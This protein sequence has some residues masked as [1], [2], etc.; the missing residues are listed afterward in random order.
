MNNK[1]RVKRSDI[2][3]RKRQFSPIQRWFHT[4][5]MLIF[6]LASIEGGTRFLLKITK[7]KTIAILPVKTV[8]E[9][10]WFKPHPH[11]LYIF[12]PNGSFTMDAFGKATI[13]SNQF[14][15]RSTREFDVKTRKKPKNSLRIATLGGS[16][17]MGVN[18]DNEI[19]PYL[20][21]KNLKEQYPEKQ[22]EIL[23]E[24]IMGYTSLDNLL[25]LSTRIIDFDPDIYV[26]YLGVN[27]ILA[28]AP[29]E[30][31]Q[32]D[33]SH[34][35][36][37]LYEQLSLSYIEFLPSWLYRLKSVRLLLEMSGVTDRRD[38][39]KNTSTV[40][41]RKHFELNAKEKNLIERKI[42]KNLRRNLKSMIAVIRAH[43]SKAQIVLGSFFDLEKRKIIEKMNK[44]FA[45]LAEK[46]KLIF[47]DIAR[48]I[49][50]DQKMT[51][52][53]GHFTK[54][55]DQYIAKLLSK[56][57]IESLSTNKQN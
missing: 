51:Y 14:S 1:N 54:E 33:H 3:R 20:I 40:Q 24:G 32:S 6:I 2:L 19:W 37:T 31:Y 12:K 23:N 36:K 48:L 18:N 34:F 22:I 15:F 35:R 47:V 10:A 27:D 9:K 25:D 52:D 46:E 41:F 49:P 17:T 16:T 43:N 7:R 4:I 55:G 5:L 21:G 38:L 45:K 29:L 13:T 42:R 53:Y 50:A 56:T 8:L 28:E 44:D 11:L 39:I 26:L 57:I 30:K